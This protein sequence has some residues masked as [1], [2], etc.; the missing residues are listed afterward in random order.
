MCRACRE[1]ALL[2]RIVSSPTNVKP[3]A[4]FEG[5]S[6]TSPQRSNARLSF[7]LSQAL[8]PYWTLHF[9][10]LRGTTCNPWRE[11]GWLVVVSPFPPPLP[12]DLS[13]KPRRLPPLLLRFPL[14]LHLL[15]V[16][17]LPTTLQ[18]PTHIFLF[19]K[20]ETGFPKAISSTRRSASILFA[21]HSNPI[22]RSNFTIHVSRR[23]SC[24]W[25][26]LSS[27]LPPLHSSKQQLAPPLG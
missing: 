24:W 15:A 16:H 20:V 3:E 12:P 11:R 1:E 7:R 23:F 19:K 10:G 21:G 25:I 18:S 22:A 2:R 26:R 14:P 13:S 6:S 5:M 8:V 27:R 9:C 17:V 4:R